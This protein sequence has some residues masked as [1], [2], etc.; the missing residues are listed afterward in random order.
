[1]KDEFSNLLT[2]NYAYKLFTIYCYLFSIY[3]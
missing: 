2:N 3:N 1:M